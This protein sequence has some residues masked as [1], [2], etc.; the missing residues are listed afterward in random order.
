METSY[1]KL[2]KGSRLTNYMRLEMAPG[3]E[4]ILGKNYL[5]LDIPLIGA[6]IDEG[7]EVVQV[8][9]SVKRNQHVWILSAAHV[10]MKGRN[11]IEVEPNPILAEY[12]QTQGLYRIHPDSGKKELGFWFTARKD[13]DLT[14]LDYAVRIYMPA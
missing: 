2:M 9:L 1:L 11:F 3:V 6:V 4:P 5:Y 7:S 10:D 12:G 8:S 14:L 13:T